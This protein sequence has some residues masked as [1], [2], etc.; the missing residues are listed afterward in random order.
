MLRA[1]FGV[2]AEASERLSAAPDASLLMFIWC[3][4]GAPGKGR[5]VFVMFSVSRLRLSATMAFLR[6]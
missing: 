6:L 3:Y 4:F 2:H 1:R 5:V